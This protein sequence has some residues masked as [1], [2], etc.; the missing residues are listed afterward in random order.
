MYN[1]CVCDLF[2]AVQDAVEGFFLVLQ[3]D[4]WRL[5]F[6]HNPDFGLL[7]SV[8]LT[9]TKIFWVD[10]RRMR[11]FAV[12]VLVSLTFRHW[13]F[14][15]RSQSLLARIEFS[16][17]CNQLIKIRW[18]FKNHPTTEYLSSLLSN[19]D[20]TF[21]DWTFAEPKEF[22]KSELLEGQG[23][24]GKTWSLLNDRGLINSV[25]IVHS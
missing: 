23:G 10:E 5:V 21:D 24:A 25:Y 17:V 9:F 7:N 18:V 8:I 13:Q 19:D 16:L 3:L 11:H 6:S 20:T 2:L 1:V 14:V 15:S 12:W 22:Y 4:A